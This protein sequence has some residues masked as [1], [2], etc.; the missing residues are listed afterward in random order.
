MEPEKDILEQWKL[1]REELSWYNRTLDSIKTKWNYEWKYIPKEIARGFKSIWYWLP[2]IWKDRNW[3]H[4]YIY[5]VLQHK[6][7]AQ[8]KYI[9]DRGFH[10]NAERDAE[11]MMT[12]VRLIDKVN[13]DWYAMEHIDYQKTKSWFEP[14]GEGYSTWKSKILVADFDRYFAEYPLIYKRVING[15]G[16][17]NLD[18]RDDLELKSAIAMNIAHINQDRA[19]KLLFKILEQNINKWWD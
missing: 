3:D 2:I 15:E 6:L 10:M 4:S 7:K 12:C 5:K 8:S 1:E 16:R 9:G 14:A 19:H 11:L 13:E 18:G 17:F